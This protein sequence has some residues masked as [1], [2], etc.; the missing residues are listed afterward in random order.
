VQWFHLTAR[1]L[2]LNVTYLVGSPSDYL[3]GY[4]GSLWIV[5]GLSGL[6]IAPSQCA[7]F[8]TTD[9]RY[10]YVHFAANHRHDDLVT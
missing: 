1:D 8:G 6:L 7:S 9:I 2:E 5:T 10:W 3:T 4:D